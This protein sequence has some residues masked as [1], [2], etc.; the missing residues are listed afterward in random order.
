MKDIFIHVGNQ[1]DTVTEV[2]FFDFDLGQFEKEQPPV[3]WPAVLFAYDE[4]V[5]EDLSAN[6]QIAE[7]TFTIRCG[8]KIYERTHNLNDA[9]ARAAALAHLDILSAIHYSLQ[10]TAGTGSS[11]YKRTRLTEEKRAD[12][13]IYAM[14][15]TC[16]LIDCPEVMDYS[17]LPDDAVADFCFS[18]DVKDPGED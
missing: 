13:R 5:Y 7:F 12:Y 9:T 2:R 18:V 14:T 8:F 10:G 4:A 1:I 15:Y 3:S 11:S 16:T 17:P 6:T